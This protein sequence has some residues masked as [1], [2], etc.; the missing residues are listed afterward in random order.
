[1]PEG[2][3]KNRGI[4]QSMVEKG[5]SLGMTLSSI[6]ETLQEAGLGYRRADIAADIRRIEGR[7]LYEDPISR[8]RPESFVPVHMVEELPY[9][10]TT[11]YWYRAKAVWTDPSTGQETERHFIWGSDDWLRPQDAIGELEDNV[12]VADYEAAMQLTSVTLIGVSH[13]QGAAY[14][15]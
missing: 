1:M 8:L 12:P 13:K 15:R 7:R 2:W 3:S 11:N 14:R 9:N 5:V 6:Q 10:M 4:A